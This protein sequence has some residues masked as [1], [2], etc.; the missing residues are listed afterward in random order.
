MI[1]SGALRPT[2][3]RHMDIDVLCAYLRCPASWTR[4]IYPRRQNGTLAP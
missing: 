1:P 3:L 4:A 2:T